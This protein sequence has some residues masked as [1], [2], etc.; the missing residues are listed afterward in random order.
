MQ[1]RQGRRKTYGPE[2][3]VA[4]SVDSVRQLLPLRN[5][6]FGLLWSGQLLS[7]IGTWLM[8]VAMPVFVFHLTHSARDTGL[9]FF[10]EVVPMVAIGPVAGVFTDRWRRRRTMVTS[11]VLRAA[12]VL[13]LI[14]FTSA[15]RLWVLLASVVAENAFGMFFTPAYRGLVPFLVGRGAELESANAWSTAAS[16]ITRLAGAPLGGVVYVALGFRWVVMLD[17][18]SYLISASCILFLPVRRVAARSEPTTATAQ[19]GRRQVAHLRDFAAEFQAGL[20]WLAH[21]RAL[22][23]IAGVTALFLLGNGALTAL[24][25]PFIATQL[26]GDATRVGALLSALG[27]GYLLS[28]YV[29]RRICTS[30]QL[31]TSVISLVAGIVIAFAGF[32]NSRSFVAALVFIGLA[33]IPGGSFLMLE[34]TLMQRLSPDDIIGRISAA[35]S[36]IENAATLCGALL[37]SLLEH[38]LGL[39][40]TLNLSIAVIAAG[41]ILAILMP[42]TRPMLALEPRH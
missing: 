42:G 25:I 7:A 29:G 37:A 14:F 27:T 28:S 20:S 33:G 39:T 3:A 12:S 10:A 17:A 35:Y 1:E 21:D 19:S 18:A 9:A 13:L 4:S 36:T 22:S 34:Q 41:G 38:A 15:D 6:S 2:I 31:R 5:G 26:H 24:L 32:F 8:V 11:N 23:V 16:G 40:A 30:P